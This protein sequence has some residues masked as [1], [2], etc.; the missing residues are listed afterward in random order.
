[1]K[2]R[3]QPS[4]EQRMLTRVQQKTPVQT[5]CIC[6][7][8]THGEG[9]AHAP[10]CPGKWATAAEGAAPGRGSVRTSRVRYKPGD[11]IIYDWAGPRFGQAGLVEHV[12][13]DGHLIVHFDVDPPDFIVVLSDSGLHLEA[14]QANADLT[15]LEIAMKAE[16][17]AAMKAYRTAAKSVGKLI[18]RLAEGDEDNAKL[19]RA[20]DALF[21]RANKAEIR[22]DMTAREEASALET[23]LR[24]RLP[25]AREAGFKARQEGRYA[26]IA[27]LKETERE[28]RS[29]MDPAFRAYQDELKRTYRS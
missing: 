29:K 7:H 13:K 4:P 19:T 16:T 21:N 3:S 28:A 15:P 10:L 2:K 20:F 23:A 26:E 18:D 6:R 8:G 25:E 5:A 9:T 17:A 24:K 27:R 1:M 14:P 12:R 11:R 22:G